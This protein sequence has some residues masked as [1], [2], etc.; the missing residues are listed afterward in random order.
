M[1]RN[2]DAR[3]VSVDGTISGPGGLIQVPVGADVSSNTRSDMDGLLWTLAAG[4]TV[5]QTEN[6]IVD[7][8]VGARLVSVEASTSWELT[9]AIIGPGG[10]EL[11]PMQGGIGNDTDLWDGIVGVRGDVGIEWDKVSSVVS[12]QNI[13]IETSDGTRYFGNLTA[14]E[15]NSSI[16]VMTMLAESGSSSD[17]LLNDCF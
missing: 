1:T 9:A 14:A 5:K 12:S 8:F 10:E 13:Q 6:S 16:I 15:E 11:L 17:R 2:G 4:F 3:V 7:V